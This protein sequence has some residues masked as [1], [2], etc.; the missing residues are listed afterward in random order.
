MVKRKSI[1]RAKDR[2]RPATK[3]ATSSLHSAPSFAAGSIVLATLREPREKIWGALLALDPAG[4]SLQGIELS[5]F[6]DATSAAIGGEPLNAAVLFFPMHRVER[7]AMDLPEGN[8]PSLSQ[9][10]Q[11][12]TGMEARD[13]LAQIAQ[14]AAAGRAG[15]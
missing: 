3:S 10:F 15:V 1:S 7:I 8:L 11:L 2:D 9:R 13:A 5:S 12:R 6:E 4:V 14:N